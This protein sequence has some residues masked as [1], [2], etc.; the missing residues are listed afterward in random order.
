LLAF[1]YRTLKLD[2]K[3]EATYRVALK[4]INKRLTMNPDDPRAAYLKS[5]TLIEL[6]KLDEGL[7][8]ADR[9]YA[10]APD[11][12]YNVYGVACSY[13]RLDRI[14]EAVDYFEKAVQCGFAH[15]EWVENDMD[16]DPIRNHP[17]FRAVMKTL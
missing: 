1:T 16:L 6:G 5:A 3:A 15:K 2:T 10:I 12:P 9:A 7:E 17:R 11:D 4:N 8:W 13:S 14:E